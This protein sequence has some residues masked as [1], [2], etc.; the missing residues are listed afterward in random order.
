MVVT[1]RGVAVRR[2]E[3]NRIE[4][5]QSVVDVAT[6]N[7]SSLLESDR[8]PDETMNQVVYVVSS[9]YTFLI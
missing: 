3:S 9:N 7:E 5:N 1:G 8:G 4:S 2:I 6:I